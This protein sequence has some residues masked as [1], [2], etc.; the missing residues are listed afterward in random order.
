MAKMLQTLPRRMED[1]D[2]MSRGKTSRRVIKNTYRKLRRK[3]QSRAAQGA[4]TALR[5]ILERLVKKLRPEEI[6]L[7]GSRAEGRAHAGSDWDL[8][9]VVPDGTDP[10]LLD[11]VA[12]WNLLRGL[13]IPVDVVPCTRSEFEEEKHEV[14]T[15]PR[16]AWTRGTRIYLRP[17]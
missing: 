6:W 10:A 11:T 7:F 8:L 4:K 16:A 17:S 3:S 5:T 1:T 12:A 13:N 14:D 2:M 15:L 9:V